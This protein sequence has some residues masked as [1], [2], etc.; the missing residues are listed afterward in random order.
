MSDRANARDVTTTRPK[1]P[2]ERKVKKKRRKKASTMPCDSVNPT[3]IP[4][5]HAA[6]VLS[7]ATDETVA[8]SESG[9]G[10]S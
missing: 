9:R 6:A 7:T 5:D 1:H 2:A 4:D 10:A 3:A 8:A